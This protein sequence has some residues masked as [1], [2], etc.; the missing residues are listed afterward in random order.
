MQ[1]LLLELA[2][3]PQP[4]L[5]TF[6]GKNGAALRRCGRRSNGERFV[7]SGARAQRQDALLRALPGGRGEGSRGCVQAPK[8]GLAPHRNLPRRR[9]RSLASGYAGRSPCRLCNRLRVSGGALARAARRRP[10]GSACGRICARASHRDRAPS[11]PPERRGQGP[12]PSTGTPRARIA[13]DGELIRYS[14][15][16]SIATW[17][18]NRGP[19]TPGQIF[20]ATQAPHHAAHLLKEALG[21][22]DAAKR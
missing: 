18:R 3:P 10:R 14:S 8:R 17:A 6:R 15:R 12:P 9:G 19:R 21:L 2:P 7:F 4:T 5:R 11:A 13:L 20:A 16:T 22:L 1:Q